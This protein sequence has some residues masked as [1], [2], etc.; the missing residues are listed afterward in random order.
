MLFRSVTWYEHKHVKTKYVT[1]TRI[2]ITDKKNNVENC[3]YYA[4]NSA[5]DVVPDPDPALIDPKGVYCGYLFL[6]SVNWEVK[7]VNTEIITHESAVPVRNFEPFP[8]H[9]GTRI[10]LMQE[11][12]VPIRSEVPGTVFHRLPLFL[13]L[14]VMPYPLGVSNTA[15]HDTESYHHLSTF[16]ILCSIC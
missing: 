4:E 12:V 7:S 16:H 8:I 1:D 5:G 15:Q 11:I 14:L 9:F 13:F 3:I 6:N 2:F 10:L